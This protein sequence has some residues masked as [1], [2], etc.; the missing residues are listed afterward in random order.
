MINIKT[1]ASGSTGNCY[2]IS[3]GDAVLMIECGIRFKLIQ[4]A[5]DY[6]LS[7]VSGCLVSHEHGDHCKAL[8]DVIRAGVNCYA[9]AGTRNGISV[10]DSR[11]L[12]I[13]KAGKQFCAGLFTILPFSVQHDAQEPVGFLLQSGS[14]KLLFATDSFYLRA[15]FRGL[16][17]IMIECNY[18]N[19]MLDENIK[20][21]AMHKSLAERTKRSHF[22]IENVKRF[23]QANDLKK[24][25]E[26]HL[27]HISKTNGD[28]DFF[29]SEIEKMV[30]IPVI[31]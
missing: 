24:V 1:I 6:Q 17:H 22:E 2:R 12:K 13:I 14:D 28:P 30:G 19:E 26:I 7:N 27:I 29:K 3:D 11:R 21:G 15:R 20:N 25:R 23:L 5:F 9:T 10:G 16:T 31:I 18:S 4:K 8:K